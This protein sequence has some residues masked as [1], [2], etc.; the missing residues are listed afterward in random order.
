MPADGLVAGGEVA[1]ALTLAAA[2]AAATA[3]AAAMY[4]SK[5]DDSPMF[6]TQVRGA[7]SRSRSRRIS[8]PCLG[9][10]PSPACVSGRLPPL[11]AFVAVAAGWPGSIL[12]SV[13]ACVSASPR[14]SPCSVSSLPPCRPCRTWPGRCWIAGTENAANKSPPL[15]FSGRSMRGACPEFPHLFIHYLFCECTWKA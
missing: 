14:M 5:L 9:S 1:E 15:L 4:F 8:A 2:A 3:T 12:R 6:R 13:P 7:R 11:P 10:P